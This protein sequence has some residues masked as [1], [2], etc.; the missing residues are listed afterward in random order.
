MTSGT[1]ACPLPSTLTG[2]PEAAAIRTVAATSAGL[3]APT[4][5][6]GVLSRERLNPATSAV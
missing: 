5:M 6:G 4:A 1:S 3:A 2:R